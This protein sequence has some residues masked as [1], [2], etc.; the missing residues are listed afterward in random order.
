MSNER[1]LGNPLT[2]KGK[3]HHHI[4]YVR[5]GNAMGDNRG[6]TYLQNKLCYL[7]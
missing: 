6:E 2:R 1:G 4:E 3:I 5:F 7:R